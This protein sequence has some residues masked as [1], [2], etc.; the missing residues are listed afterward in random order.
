MSKSLFMLPFLKKNGIVILL[1]AQ[2]S[3]CIPPNNSLT[4]KIKKNLSGVL[5]L[6][7]GVR[8]TTTDGKENVTCQR[9]LNILLKNEAYGKSAR[10]AI[11]EILVNEKGFIDD[12]LT[13]LV[14]T[15]VKQTI[16]QEKL[17][18]AQKLEFQKFIDDAIPYT[19]RVTN[20]SKSEQ[21][22]RLFD[23]M[24][25]HESKKNPL[26]HIETIVKNPFDKSELGCNMYGMILQSLVR[27]TEMIRFV[28]VVSNSGNFSGT[29]YTIPL[30]SYSISPKGVGVT[31]NY[32][33][34]IQLSPFQFQAN[35]LEGSIKTNLMVGISNLGSHNFI[36]VYIPASSS[37]DFYIYAQETN[38]FKAI[39]KQLEPKQCNQ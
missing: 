34:E 11:K 15:H 32:T 7:N 19:F 39:K 35:C 10:N 5:V 26:V 6:E 18:S 20:L 30:V 24:D 25:L 8:Y 28:K 31:K 3:N 4:P 1:Y 33:K 29:N 38:H 9:C 27:Q 2:I 37:F 12:A 21:R 17:A 22:V 36:E 13:S 23:V 16:A 14:K